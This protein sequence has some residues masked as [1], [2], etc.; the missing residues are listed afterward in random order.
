MEHFPKDFQEKPKQDQVQ[1]VQLGLYCWSILEQ[2][3]DEQ[4]DLDLTEI[5][6]LIR[7]KGREEGRKQKEFEHSQEINV[8]TSQLRLLQTEKDILES[9]VK[10]EFEQ[11]KHILVKSTKLDLEREFQTMKEENI[12][13]KTKQ[14]TEQSLVTTC[15]VQADHILELRQKI[16]ALEKTKSSATLGKEGEHFVERLLST[17]PYEYEMTQDKAEKADIRITTKS[18]KHFILDSKKYKTNVGK[19]EKDKL[20]RDVDNDATVCG[21]ILV[22]IDT[23]IT[24]Q[25]HGDIIF[26]SNNKPILLITLMG[27]TLEAQIETLHISIKVLEQYT[28]LHEQK[29]RADLVEKIKQAMVSVKE[30]IQRFQNIEKSAKKILEDAKAGL[31]KLEPLQKILINN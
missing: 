6:K 17:L 26:T 9:K 2:H 5:H 15:K 14:E 11:E 1:I 27:M 31:D 18:G 29:E 19:K 4:K 7:E 24:H 30:G 10:K 8:L 28:N 16:E 23:K 21:G 3:I 25:D 22:S 12:R 20:A 13:L